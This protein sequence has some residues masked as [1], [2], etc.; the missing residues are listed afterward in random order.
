MLQFITHPCVKYSIIEQVKMVLDGGCKW[1][2]LRMPNLSIEEAKSIIEEII[3]ICKE[4][5][6]ILIIEDYVELSKDLE[7][8][9]VHISKNVNKIAE[10]RNTLEGGPIIGV[11]VNTASD[12]FAL[13]GIDVD[14]VSIISSKEENNLSHYAKIVD[15]VRTVGVELPIVAVGEFS[16][17]NIEAVMNTGVNGIALSESIIKA[18]NPT[19]Y[20]KTI[21]SKLYN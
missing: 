4:F 11:N 1:I 6:A 18:E 16:I 17:E 15:E 2:Q 5:D 3:P 20:T 8:T 9:G 21:L 14:Y 10:I 13:K 7:V 19:E 12:I